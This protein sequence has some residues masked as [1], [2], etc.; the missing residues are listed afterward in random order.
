MPQDD[1]TPAPILEPRRIS[2]IPSVIPEV[3]VDGLLVDTETIVSQE[4][5]TLFTSRRDL[6]RDPAEEIRK[7]LTRIDICDNTPNIITTNQKSHDLL[8]DR[9]PIPGNNPVALL[10]RDN[11]KLFSRVPQDKNDIILKEMS[12]EELFALANKGNTQAQVSLGD[13]YKDGEQGFQK[14]C[15][16]AIEWY[17][18]AAKQ[19]YAE[20]QR[21]VG[22]MY[23]K[24]SGIQQDYKKAMLWNFKAAHQGNAIA[25]YNIGCMYYYGEG[26]SQDYSQAMIWFLKAAD[27]ALVGYQCNL[28]VLKCNNQDN[29]QSP[30]TAGWCL[31][32]DSQGHRRTRYYLGVMYHKGQGVAQDYS[33]AMIWY[34]KSAELE[35]AIAQRSIGAMY[36]K[37]QGTPKDYSLALKWFLK[38]AK[39]GDA[40]AEHSIG[41]LCENGRGVPKDHSEAMKWYQKAMDHNHK[42]AKFKL[43]RLKKND[44]S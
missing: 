6:N 36:L 10:P 37:G 8:H 9:S 11:V 42:S 16:I 3:V 18:K 41:S 28:G 44:I 21:R 40:E 5:L 35:L 12:I 14:D 22:H 24:G 31:R 15:Q 38:A 19:G 34:Q 1:T 23:S 29:L 33:Q 7:E 20:A 30:Q 43:D 2:A 17:L 32:V 25:W 26:V 13:M 4:P 27:G 39:Q